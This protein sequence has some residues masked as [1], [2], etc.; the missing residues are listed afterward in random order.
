[1]NFGGNSD[2]CAGQNLTG[3]LEVTVFSELEMSLCRCGQSAGEGTRR[4]VLAHFV[5]TTRV[6]PLGY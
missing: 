3:D 6:T 4:S 1:M 5:A 2:G